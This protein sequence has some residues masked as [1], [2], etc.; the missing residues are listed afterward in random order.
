MAHFFRFLLVVLF[1]GA[2]Y[3]YIQGYVLNKPPEIKQGES[4]TQTD[5][6]EPSQSDNETY[7]PA[8]RSESVFVPYWAAMNGLA[9]EE[10][11]RLIYFGVS[12]TTSGVDTSDAG[13][14]N[15]GTFVEAAG[16]NDIWLTVRMLNHEVN[17][18][19]LNDPDTWQPVAADIARVASEN[20]FDGV[21]LD[22]EVGLVSFHIKPESITGFTQEVADAVQGQ[23]MP[24]AITL[25][26]DTYY[27]GRPYDVKALGGIADEVMLM[28]YDFHKSF[29]TPGPNFPLGGRNIYN[30]DF[31]TM[32][33]DFTSQVPREKLSIIFGMYGYE[34]IVDDQERPLKAAEAVTLNQV[35]QR[36]IPDCDESNCRVER[37]ETSAETK[38]TFT[39]D[40]E[41]PHV[42]WY[43]DEQSVE[44]KR[45]LLEK[46]GI[47]QIIYWAYGYF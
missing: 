9:S 47:G 40:Q 33:N 25:Y 1:I 41:R 16:D 23:G 11:D 32:V 19:I 43:E 27:R 15:M 37:D 34:W 22:L 8:S 44:K 17:S 24:L 30:Y 39:G 5:T 3:M 45:E 7:T 38:V 46:E 20:G 21:V 29:G 31:T 42:V 2:A 18:D 4:Q 28:A 10:Y 14:R 35:R 36:F 12:P 13:Y 6:T 26:G